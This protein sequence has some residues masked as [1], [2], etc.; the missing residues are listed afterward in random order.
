MKP[1]KKRI[2]LLVIVHVA[3]FFICPLFLPS[4]CFCQDNSEWQVIIED[5]P[6]QNIGIS[7]G[8]KKH[9]AKPP[10]AAAIKATPQRAG[11]GDTVTLRVQIPAAI[12]NNTGRVEIV[13]P[14]GTFIASATGS[15][16]QYFWQVPKDITKTVQINCMVLAKKQDPYGRPIVIATGTTRVDIINLSLS[17][18]AEGYAHPISKPSR[19]EAVIRGGTPPYACTWFLGGPSKVGQVT[20]HGTKSYSSTMVHTWKRTGHHRVGVT[21]TDADGFTRSREATITIHNLS[22][23]AGISAHKIR[24]KEKVAITM[25]ASGGKAPYVFTLD[26]GNQ[27]AI[28]GISSPGMT[29]IRQTCSYTKPG[30]YWVKAIVTDAHES[31][32]SKEFG[33][34]VKGGFL[35]LQNGGYHEAGEDVKLTV[36]VHDLV[37]PFTLNITWG[38]DGSEKISGIYTKTHYFH[39]VFKKAGRY[40]V[41]VTAKDAED[42]RA[43]AGLTIAVEK[44][45]PPCKCYSSEINCGSGLCCSPK[46]FPCWNMPAIKKAI[47]SGKCRD[48][49]E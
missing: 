46:D 45:D 35:I 7:A 32:D 44:K 29:A 48:I 16:Y 3:I 13:C 39:H 21:F 1:I 28:L 5:D 27:G 42:G 34:R 14:N 25:Q 40:A 20:K 36:H 49:C 18:R 43:S 38:H 11:P 19:F 37:A 8:P 22:L 2:L 17:F 10:Q 24:P 41:Q 33:V 6:V 23:N 4:A 30:Q 47:K 12:K 31:R 9:I 26:C 15:G